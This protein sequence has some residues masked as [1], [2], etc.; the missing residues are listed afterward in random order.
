MCAIGQGLGKQMVALITR[1]DQ[2]LGRAV[3]NAVEVAE[4]VDCL[5]G[6]RPGRPGDPS[7]ELAAEM[8]LMAGR[9][10]RSEQA[11]RSASRRSTT[12]R[13]STDSGWSRPGGRPRAVDDPA[14]A[15]A[16]PQDRAEIPEAGIVQ[17]GRAAGRPRHHAAGRGPARMD[18]RDRPAGRRDL[19]QESRRRSSVNEP[20]C[21]VLVNDESRLEE[22]W[23]DPG[24]FRSAES[25]SPRQSLIVERIASPRGRRARRDVDRQRERLF[26][27]PK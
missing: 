27:M 21:T 14:P 25:P 8:V 20:L 11:A 24:S 10:A 13:P 1:M 4:C 7:I 18:S 17:R 16:A 22:A 5:R 2:P 26:R 12:A 3:G 6:E 23:P 9:P 19:A 15:G